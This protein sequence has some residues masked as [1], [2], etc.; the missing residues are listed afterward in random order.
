[1]KFLAKFDKK[2]AENSA[3]WQQHVF[4]VAVLIELTFYLKKIKNTIF[5]ENFEKI[6]Q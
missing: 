3:T 4:S 5:T 1:M 2:I 6:L